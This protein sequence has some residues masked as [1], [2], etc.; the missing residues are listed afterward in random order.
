MN[1]NYTKPTIEQ[2]QAELEW[3]LARG[4]KRT[5]ALV[6]VFAILTAVLI[7]VSAILPGTKIQGMVASYAM[8]Q[9]IEWGTVTET[10]AEPA[11]AVR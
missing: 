3:E 4:K 6:S 9:Q 1:E 5:S 8:D 10:P 11:D 7:A 2:L